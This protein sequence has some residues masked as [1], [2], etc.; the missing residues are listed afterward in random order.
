MDIT[1]GQ[2][3]R[4]IEANCGGL[5]ALTD[6]QVETIWRALLPDSQAQY[7]AKVKTERKGKKDADSDKS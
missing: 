2:K 7:L 3:R 4:A 6:G 5:G 1:I